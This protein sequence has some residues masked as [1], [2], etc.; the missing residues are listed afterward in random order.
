MRDPYEVLGVPRGATKEQV[1]AAYRELAKKY[2]PDN[3]IDSPL[4]EN[5]NK[6]CR[7]S[8]RLMMQ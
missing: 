5:A 4:A 2:H 6:K 8:M 1:K 3:Y 7:K